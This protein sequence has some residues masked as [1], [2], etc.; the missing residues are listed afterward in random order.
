MRILLAGGGTAGHINPAIAIADTVKAHEPDSEIA[1]IATSGGLEKDLIGKAGYKTY[2]I[3]MSGLQR[4]LS[5][6]NIKTAYYYLTAPHKAKKLMKE[7]RPDVVVG[8]GSYLSW[9]LIKAAY[10]L[11]IPCAVHESNSIP[12]KAVKMLAGKVNR[13]YL[14][15]P[16][17]ADELP[18]KYGSKT[19][20]VG[21]PLVQ[22]ESAERSEDLKG[23]LGIPPSADHV[24]LAFGGSQG[25]DKL[26]DVV[27][28]VAARFKEKR[29]NVFFVLSAGGKKY[30]DV[31]KIAAQKG[32]AESENIRIMQY[33]YN[34]PEWEACA[35]T[36]I[37]RAGAM[38]LSE[39]ALA[40]KATIAVPSPY[41]VNDHQYKNAKMLADEGA[42]IL[43]AEKDLT[44]ER[45]SEEL[46]GLISNAAKRRKLSENIRRFAHP[47]AKE[48][49]YADLVRLIEEND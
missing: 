9:P 37:C 29:P 3:E 47:D 4:S 45:L 17:V 8:T 6:R 40:G 26:N 1:F 31:M 20:V 33:I 48:A 19:L 5:P 41:V 24:I 38:T 7:F 12:G 28:G 46:D 32:V 25:A 30:A 21:N 10:A 11:G 13:I 22:S 14:N 15:F 39:M 23:K 44:V 16:S 18:E 2:H 49:I 35:D 27:L 43:I 42:A 36:V 34:M